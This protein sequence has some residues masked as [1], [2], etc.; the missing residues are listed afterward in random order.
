M[1]QPTRP[2]AA[3]AGDGRVRSVRVPRNHPAGPRPAGS[4]TVGSRTVDTRPGRRTLNRRPRVAYVL[5]VALFA[6][7][8]TPSAVTSVT[9]GSG[10]VPLTVL[11]GLG[12]AF[13]GAVSGVIGSLILDVLLMLALRVA[14]ADATLR[15]ASA[16]V[17]GALLPLAV[18][19]TAAAGFVLVQ[20]AA[21]AFASPVV[22]V[23]MAAAVAAHGVALFLNLRPVLG[24][25]V[26]RRL[27]AV[28]CYA[29]VPAG[30]IGA[31]QALGGGS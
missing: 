10:S 14:G 17:D 24:R 22:S 5:A 26:G 15:Q 20:G 18:G 21:I 31:A 13:F 3:G 28:I 30:V 29:V 25:S 16:R 1:T 11:S 2:F 19:V 7:A 23:L 4:R 6:A 9:G 27:A 12:L 8:F